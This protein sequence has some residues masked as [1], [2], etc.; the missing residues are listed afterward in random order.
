MS[1]H[2]Y[3]LFSYSQFRNVPCSFNSEVRYQNFHGMYETCQ[4]T[5]S[6]TSV[7][8]NHATWATVSQRTTQ[9]SNRTQK[10][11]FFCTHFRY[12]RSVTIITV[13]L[14]HVCEENI[15]EAPSLCSI[16]LSHGTSTY[17]TTAMFLNVHLTMFH[18]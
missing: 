11:C 15:T 9:C 10:P 12:S 13:I 3:K 14:F 16:H 17:H 6:N 18:T 5:N 8:A 7:V 2:K 4:N 1:P